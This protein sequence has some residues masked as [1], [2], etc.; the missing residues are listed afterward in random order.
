MLADGRGRVSQAGIAVGAYLGCRLG[1]MAAFDDGAT[2]RILVGPVLFDLTVAIA[3]S[4][5]R[6]SQLGAFRDQPNLFGAI[7]LTSAAWLRLGGV[8]A[9]GLSAVRAAREQACSARVA[10]RRE[11]SSPS[12][13]IY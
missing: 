9:A 11:W 3:D 6:M 2:G 8:D 4:T 12:T 13:R 10:G 1:L 5:M 7:A